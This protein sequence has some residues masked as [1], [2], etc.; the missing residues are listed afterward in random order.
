[1]VIHVLDHHS[2]SQKYLQG[3]ATRKVKQRP[4][5]VIPHQMAATCILDQYYYLDQ[6]WV[7]TRTKN[8]NFV[9]AKMTHQD[10]E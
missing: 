2:E 5:A 8:L 9:P 4:K 3:F 1:M 10:K 6:L 7:K